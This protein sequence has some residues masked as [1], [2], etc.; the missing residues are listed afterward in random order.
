MVV[1]GDQQYKVT[2]V[3]NPEWVIV[4]S[5]RIMHTYERIRKIA[6]MNSVQKGSESPESQTIT[7]N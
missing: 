2:W 3:I 6:P 5:I 7:K 1:G 4:P